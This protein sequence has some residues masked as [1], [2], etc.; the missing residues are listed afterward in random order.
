[1]LISAA[2]GKKL[3]Y[4]IDRDKDA[5]A[6]YQQRRF[7][8]V[9][10]VGKRTEAEID[11]P[12][13]ERLNVS[14]GAPQVIFGLSEIDGADA[15]RAVKLADE[16]ASKGFRTLGVARTDKDGNWRFLRIRPLFDPPREESDE[17]IRQAEAHG[18]EVKMVTGDN[19]AIAR[20][21]AGRMVA[22]MLVYQFYPITA[23]MIILL[24]LLNDILIMAIAYENT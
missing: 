24:A 8:P 11:G 22:A 4:A 16:L 21:I 12:D 17:T 15:E 23:I 14:K 13:D 10:P 6:H 20:E 5:L 9:D 18:V 7:V 19:T 3:N 2:I 1:M